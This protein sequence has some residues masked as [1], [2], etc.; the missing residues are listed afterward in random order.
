M[1]TEY[2]ILSIS[3]PFRLTCCSFRLF[4]Y[5]ISVSF[6][7][8]FQL[9]E[10]LRG[11][12]ILN[13]DDRQTVSDLKKMAV[14]RVGKNFKQMGCPDGVGRVRLSEVRSCCCLA[15]GE[16]S[17]SVYMPLALCVEKLIYV[18]CDGSWRGSVGRLIGV[19]SFGLY[20]SR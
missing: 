1:L 19:C 5:A 15:S 20:F 14:E 18:Y 10:G 4:C 3:W 11:P 6:M 2:N 9:P 8:R 13:M 16:I 17:C 12:L 7:V